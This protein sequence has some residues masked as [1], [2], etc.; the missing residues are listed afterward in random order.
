MPHTAVLLCLQRVPLA[1]ARLPQ[2]GRRAASAALGCPR[3]CALLPLD[4]HP[5][6]PAQ[7]ERIRTLSDCAQQLNAAHDK[8]AGRMLGQV[9][10]AGLRLVFVCV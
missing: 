5:C 9:R 3:S 2:P 10:L 1:V 4:A 6:L 7:I 8:D